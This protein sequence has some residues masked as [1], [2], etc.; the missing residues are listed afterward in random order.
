MLQLPNWVKRLFHK[1]KWGKRLLVGV[2]FTLFLAFFL[3]DREVVVESLEVNTIAEKYVLAQVGFE[4]PDVEATTLLKQESMRDIGRVYQLDEKQILQWNTA[5]EKK[6]VEDPD[7]RQQLPSTTFE[8]IY[9]AKEKVCELLL[10]STF[11]DERTF[12]KLKEIKAP[13]EGLYI[14]PHT[15]IADPS[16]EVQYILG[17]VQKEDW[18]MLE[19]L[20]AQ[21]SIRQTVKASIP[22]KRTK[23]EAGSRII[24]AGERITPRHLEM[25]KGMKKVLSEERNQITPLTILGSFLLAFLLTALSVMYLRIQHPQTIRSF[26]KLALLATILILTMSIAK[27][28]EYFVFHKANNLVELFHYP[29]FVLFGTLLASLLVSREV[30]LVISCFLVVVLGISLAVNYDHFLVINV[31]SALVAIIAVRKIRRRKEIF[32]ACVKVWLSLIPVIIAFNLFENTFWHFHLVVDLSTTFLFVSLTAIL[33]V[34]LL[35]ILE[36]AFDVLTDMTL[37]EYADPNHPLLRR[38]SVETPGTYQ[39][40]LVVGAITEAAATSIRANGLFCRIATLYHDIGKLY[41]PHYFTEN[42]LG[43]FNIHHLLTPQESAQVIISH[44]IDG[45]ALAEK[46]RL[47]QSFIDIIKEHHGTSLVYCFYRAQLELSGGESSLFNEDNFRYKGP[48]PRTKESAIIMI[49]DCVEA[50]FRSLDEVTELHVTAMVEGLIAEKIQDGQLNDCH[51][52]FEEL[53]KIKQAMI[54]TLLA[55]RHSRVKYPQPETAFVSKIE[56]IYTRVN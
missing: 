28:T 3:H 20:D 48:K 27:L 43:G 17:C 24:N 39:H 10:G 18:M 56:A 11:V 31:V 6:L 23:I 7:W 9:A 29:I 32:E 4:F 26:Q 47:P 1:D 51:L 25:I 2:F 54:R 38:L 5:L 33:V 44:A 55:T 50:A 16:P 46:Y 14:S 37:M 19:D 12:Q 41:N 22:I 13:L 40:S 30:G 53:G 34:G 15:V 45:T 8:A 21:H 49:G 42:Q 35:P 36:S 52:T